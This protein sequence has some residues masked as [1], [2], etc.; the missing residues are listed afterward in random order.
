MQHLVNRPSAPADSSPGKMVIQTAITE[1]ATQDYPAVGVSLGDRLMALSLAGPDALLG[2]A[3][4]VLQHAVVGDLARQDRVK[5]GL[6]ERLGLGVCC[7]PNHAPPYRQLDNERL[8]AAPH[9]LR[10]GEM[11]QTLQDF[12]RACSLSPDVANYARGLMAR[13]WWAR[14]T[15]EAVLGQFADVLTRS[16]VEVALLFHAAR[17]D[18]NP[19]RYLSP[20]I[21]AVARWMLGEELF[22]KPLGQLQTPAAQAAD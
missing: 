8:A 9:F 18:D 4:L 20:S 1:T 2:R 12:H 7:G 22:R 21:P 17:N 14:A 19:K 10:R 15:A 16:T 6:K 3:A 5:P 11:V 13:E